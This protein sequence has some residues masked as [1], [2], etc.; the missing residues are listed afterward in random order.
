LIPSL[1]IGFYSLYVNYEP[2]FLNIKVFTMW[3]DGLMESNKANFTLIENNVLNEILGILIIVSSMFV[4]FSRQEIEDEF[5]EKIRLESL[6]WA[7]YLNYVVLLLAM[8]FVYDLSFFTI[9]TINMFT[10]LFFFIIRF[11]WE[12]FKL[13]KASKNE[14]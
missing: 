14:E 3:N 2:E 6:V 11:N 4:A 7:T 13:K 1:F 5:I 12:L 8:I 9:M 10:I